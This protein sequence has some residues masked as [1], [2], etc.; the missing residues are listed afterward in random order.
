G[1]RVRAAV[2]VRAYRCEMLAVGTVRYGMHLTRMFQGQ[3]YLSSGRVPHL[4]VLALAGR[5]QTAAV[6]TECQALDV[7][8]IPEAGV[9]RLEGQEQ[10][11]GLGVPDRRLDSFANMCVAHLLKMGIEPAMGSGDPL[12]VWADG[13]TIHR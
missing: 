6:G 4:D 11:A 1:L 12:A 5:G 13:N 3:D 10:F 9:L 8:M 7:V 2:V